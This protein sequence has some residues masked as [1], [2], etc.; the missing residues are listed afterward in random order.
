MKSSALAASPRPM[1][2]A[3]GRGVLEVVDLGPFENNHNNIVAINDLRQCVGV[4]L[5]E[6]TG[7]IEAFRQEED[8]RAMLGTLG[9]SFSIARDLNNCGDVV[10]GSLTEGDENF[11]AFLFHGNKL[12]DLNGL[13]ERGSAWEVI[14]ALGI[15]NQGDILGI[16]TL[17]G[18][19]RIV[20]I[21]PRQERYPF[22]W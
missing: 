18:R 13:L 6:V 14:Q 2:D 15:N 3:T 5:N 20:L 7:R 21:R 19:D 8:R 11:H 9:G 1:P 10:G 16:A 4:C 22:R 12:Y 17:D